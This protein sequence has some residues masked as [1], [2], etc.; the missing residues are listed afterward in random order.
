MTWTCGW[1]AFAGALG[2]VVLNACS[3]D[4]TPSGSPGAA[5]SAAG[6]GASAAGSGGNAAGSGA[7]AGGAAGSLTA[8]ECTAACQKAAAAN[9]PNE[10]PQT[11]CVSGCNEADS[12]VT[13]KCLAQFRATISCAA[14]K[15]SFVCSAKGKAQLQG[16]D[17]EV[18]ASAG[19]AVCEPA[20]SDDACVTCEKSSCCSQ[21]KALVADASQITAYSVCVGNC[22]DATC[23]QSC[24]TQYPA[25]GALGSCVTANCLQA[26]KDS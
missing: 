25:A 8:N 10:D 7:S 24:A 15:G 9:C 2:L 16:C 20:A 1:V 12:N 21:L 22:S 13:A 4:T 26:C 11:E 6:A 23:M 14:G 3:S 5:G 17:T 19:C 18:A